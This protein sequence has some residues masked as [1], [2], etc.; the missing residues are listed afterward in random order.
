MVSQPELQPLQAGE[1]RRAQI[2][3]FVRNT[4]INALV[5]FF[6]ALFSAAILIPSVPPAPL[7]IWLAFHFIG[8]VW[9]LQR[10]RA[11]RHSEPQRPIGKR[12]V[13]RAVL[14]SAASGLAW[15]ATAFFMPY[16][17]E[18]QQLALVIVISSMAA[19]STA[20]LAPLPLA[21]GVY[22]TS[23]VSPHAVGFLVMGGFVNFLL[24]LS[25]I[26]FN[27]AMVL[28]ARRVY[29][30]FLE[31]LESR[32]AIHELKSQYERA[33]EE[34][35]AI[36]DSGEAFALF[37]ASGH[38]LLW[39][40]AFVRLWSLPSELV[41]KGETLEAL[42]RGGARPRG[43]VEPELSRWVSRRMQLHLDAEPLTEQLGNGRWLF[44]RGRR[45]D[46]AQIVSVHMDVTALKVSEERL[47]QREN[48]L[49]QARRLEAIGRLA[50]GV[51]HDFNNLLTVV[52]GYAEL[53]MVKS[54]T[55]RSTEWTQHAAREI[56]TA[57]ERGAS[58]S[59]E[60][61][62]FGQRRSTQLVRTD[63]NQ[64]IVD[65]ESM[66]RRAISGHVAMT[67]RLATEAC[68][69]DGDRGQIEQ[70]VVNLLANAN[71]AM[72][73]DGGSLVVSTRQLGKHVILAVS[74]TGPGIP[75]EVREH[76][77]EPFYTTKAFGQGTGLGLATVHGIVEQHGGHI[78]VESESGRGT[79]F[80]ISLPMRE[81]PIGVAGAFPAVRH[82]ADPRA[83]ILVVDDEDS[84]RQLVVSMLESD[85]FQVASVAS[86]EAAI[87]LA[88][89]HFDLVIT[90]VVMPGMGGVALRDQ[91][92][93]RKPDMPVLVMSGYAD[94]MAIGDPAAVLRKPFSR[95]LLIST[96]RAQLRTAVH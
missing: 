43:M 76:M 74:D 26:I 27:I 93:E 45:I 11:R 4:P 40:E 19:G 47:R 75:E 38:L 90:D 59:R 34:W 20:T 57:A 36:S 35:S 71:D 73:P 13:N 96:V 21:A 50:G 51:A 9:A 91:L 81:P 17:D 82:Q 84:V 80:N 79:T 66:L 44:S 41:R 68:W 87:L 16:L 94:R 62:T 56:L 58:L 67:I 61:L 2:A 46:N 52:R 5:T 3:A 25:A 24:A 60:L 42:L 65:M 30:T 15:G 14:W 10:W 64:L 83:R 78:A 1:I 33:R 32:H 22:V 77:F 29:D 55:A 8:S 18:S 69:V 86:G 7:S 12:G 70:V 63:L 37:D 95:D 39:N 53:L 92:L 54:E 85:G 28:A 89:D 6:V 23:I 49:A 48:D 88:G 72:M 31:G